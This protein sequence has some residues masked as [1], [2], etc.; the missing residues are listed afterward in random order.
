MEYIDGC[1]LEEYVKNNAPLSEKEAIRITRAVANALKKMHEANLLHLDV[2]PANIMIAKNGRVI[3]IDFG[4][5]HKFKTN[6]SNTKAVNFKSNGFSPRE[7]VN[8]A[9]ETYDIYM[10]GMTLYFMLSRVIGNNEEASR[11]YNKEGKLSNLHPLPNISEGLWMCIEKATR[12]GQE[13]RHQSIDEFLAML[14]S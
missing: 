3:L 8:Y 12:D 11:V 6:T 13:Y 14:P 10:L 5:A 7:N 9:D 4:A 1:N 2:K